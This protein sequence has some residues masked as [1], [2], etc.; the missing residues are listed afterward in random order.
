MVNPRVRLI[1]PIA[2]GGMASV[3]AAE[4]LDQRGERVAVKLLSRDMLSKDPSLR[5]RIE[6]EASIARALD[7]PHAVQTYESGETADGTPYIV[8]ELL[9]GI[10]L[11][12]AVMATGALELHEVRAVV[13]QVAAVL[14]CAH[15][16]GIVHRDI[17]PDNIFLVE[18]GHQVFVKVLDFGIAKNATAALAQLTQ[19]G[20]IIGTPEFMAPEQAFSSKDV[21]LR[22]DLFAL[23]MVVYFALTGELPYDPDGDTGAH[24]LLAH[25][26]PIRISA[27]R[28]DL[29]EAM[30]RWFERALA[31]LPEKRF[32]SAEQ[33]AAAFEAAVAGVLVSKPASSSDDPPTS[34]MSALPDSLE[35]PTAA[36]LGDGRDSGP[37][38]SEQ[39]TASRAVPPEIVALPSAA[40]SGRL[41]SPASPASGG[42]PGRGSGDAPLAPPAPL[43]SSPELGA[44]LPSSPDLSGRR[45]A[46]LARP[47]APE[48]RDLRPIL[49]VALIVLAML[50]IVIVK[51]C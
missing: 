14:T 1:E 29:G 27:K 26:Q 17:K 37:V 2:E 40:N 20:S 42:G 24:W 15:G 4:N 9:Q 51:V 10:D 30:D 43:P 41:A 47:H 12:R 3:W 25:R 21:D 32:Q 48:K 49:V 8:M 35:Q 36:F 6:R 46:V 50:A 5:E 7:S 31:L 22:A 16:A 28:S 13:K 33:M 45:R 38:S 19:I 44:P 39:I 23:G 11:G 18:T 34:E